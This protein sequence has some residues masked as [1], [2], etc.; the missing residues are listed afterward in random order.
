ME[1]QQEHNHESD[2]AIAELCNDVEVELYDP[3]MM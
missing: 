2:L 1:R 3:R